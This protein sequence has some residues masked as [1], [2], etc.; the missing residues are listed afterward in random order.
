MK[1][2]IQDL[3]AIRRLLMNELNKTTKLELKE[4]LDRI[5]KEIEAKDYYLGRVVE[6]CPRK[7]ERNEE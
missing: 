7:Y 2:T 4:L 1:L 3:L 6:W 5:N